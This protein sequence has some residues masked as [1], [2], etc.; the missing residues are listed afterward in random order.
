MRDSHSRRT[1]RPP[2]RGHGSEVTPRHEAVLAKFKTEPNH[3]ARYLGTHVHVATAFK[4]GREEDDYADG[5]D[6]GRSRGRGEALI[7]HV[8]L[9]NLS[10]ELVGASLCFI[11]DVLVTHVP[12]CIANYRIKIITQSHQPGAW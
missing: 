12:L 10:G 7:G 4:K 6:S 11:S 2:R 9:L 5:G 3:M 1:D 8:L